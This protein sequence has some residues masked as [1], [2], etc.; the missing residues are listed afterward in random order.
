MSHY[1]EYEDKNL[2]MLDLAYLSSECPQGLS[3]GCD[4]YCHEDSNGVNIIDVSTIADGV[5]I[6]FKSFYIAEKQKLYDIKRLKS[7]LTNDFYC[8]CIGN[9]NWSASDGGF[10]I[11]QMNI[12]NKPY[13]Y[14]GG[15]SASSAS[16]WFNVLQPCSWY[17]FHLFMAKEPIFP[18]L[19][20][21]SPASFTS[22]VECYLEEGDL[23]GVPTGFPNTKCT[24]R[25]T[26]LINAM[27]NKAVETY[28]ETCGECPV[29]Y[30]FELLMNSLLEADKLDGVDEKFGCYPSGLQ[31]WTDLINATAGFTGGVKY[32]GVIIGNVL[33]GTFS[34]LNSLGVPTGKTVVVKL[35]LEAQ[36]DKEDFLTGL[37]S[38]F[39]ISF[40]D[41]LKFCCVEFN[42]AG[43]NGLVAQGTEQSFYVSVTVPFTGRDGHKRNEKVKLEGTID[44][45]DFMDCSFTNCAKTQTAMDLSRFLSTISFNYDQATQGFTSGD[46]SGHN[47]ETFYSETE[48]K[49]DFL[50]ITDTLKL[51]G[52]GGTGVNEITRWSWKRTD[53]VILDEEKTVMTAMLKAYSGSVGNFSYEGSTEFVFTSDTDID[54]STIVRFL[55]VSPHSDADTSNTAGEE[56]SFRAVV[57]LFD[58]TGG[59]STQVLTV[60]QDLHQ[61]KTGVCET[62]GRSAN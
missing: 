19:K 8:G 27:Q 39:T 29:T 26:L 16:Q 32:S 11:S 5:W 23:S 30:D 46:F 49:E 33:T 36:Y 44:G 14:P 55:S 35:M 4:G 34:E 48:N 52:P 25:D 2:R 10:L 41:I 56:V 50:I 28:M 47:N 58:A 40:D 45:L 12:S 13:H 60:T 59:Y 62:Y 61:F 9:E 3:V 21:E 7:S 53:A 15:T 43:G 38:S 54:F 6:A 24:T 1:K 57:E 51:G 31:G 42:P 18:S 20:A 22:G 17:K 37:D